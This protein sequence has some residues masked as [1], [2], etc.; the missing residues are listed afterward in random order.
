MER[1]CKEMHTKTAA[2]KQ[3]TNALSLLH[4][5][6]LKDTRTAE[7]SIEVACMAE[8]FSQYFNTG[9]SKEIFFQAG[10]L[11]DIGKIWFPEHFFQNVIITKKEDWNV[12]KAHPEQSKEILESFGLEQAIIQ[13]AYEH[14]EK[15]NGT[16]YPKGLKGESISFLG[17]ILAIVDSYCAITEDRPYRAGANLRQAASILIKEKEKY[18][19]KLLATFI[20]NLHQIDKT[21]RKKEQKYKKKLYNNINLEHEQS[22]MQRRV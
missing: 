14:H 7:H 15:Y 3:N 12:I 20:Q 5:L 6:A 13:A 10:L 22:K 16:G 19:T 8:T 11:H 1:K 17:R 2:N 21:T 9:T 4:R 18:D